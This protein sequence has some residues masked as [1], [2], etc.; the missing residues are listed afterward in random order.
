VAVSKIVSWCC[1][2]LMEAAWRIKCWM[3][4]ENTKF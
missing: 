1:T 3:F 2:I 4:L